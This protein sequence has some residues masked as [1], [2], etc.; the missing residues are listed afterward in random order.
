MRRASSGALS[1]RAREGAAT[2]DRPADCPCE[3]RER[4]FVPIM[5]PVIE[6]KGVKKAFGAVA[7][8]KGVDLEFYLGE[9]LA[10]VGDNGAGKSTLIKV[11][12]GVCDIDDG[13][14]LIDGRTVSIKSPKDAKRFGIETIY[15]DLALCD[16][17][18]IPSNVFLGRELTKTIIPGLFKVFDHKSMRQRTRSLLGDLHIGSL[19][20]MTSQ[21]H[22]LSGGQRQ[23]VAIAKTVCFDARIIIMDEPTAAL[24]VTQT[25]QVLDL[26]RRL[27]ERGCCV[28]YISHIMRDVLE[29]ADRIA[30]MKSGR[31]VGVRQSTETDSDEL[32]F[33][34]ISGEDRKSRH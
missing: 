11:L 16:N 28:I 1:G 30:V 15:Q 34:M 2:L 4:I 18:D 21:V 17:L 23:S 29:T 12:S 10:I 3:A 19:E 8:L 24:G 33:M 20:S 6:I 22:N 32:I 9:V 26:A 25:S 31:V 14:I 5:K 27:S 7:A 13:S